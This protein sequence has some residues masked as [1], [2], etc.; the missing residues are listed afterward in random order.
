MTSGSDR[1]GV[2]RTDWYSFAS[3]ALELIYETSAPA[4]R[5]SWPGIEEGLDLVAPI[6]LVGDWEDAYLTLPGGWPAAA[7]NG[8]I[9]AAATPVATT[10]GRELPSG[11]L[12][13]RP[14]LRVALLER[15]G[16]DR[17]VMGP[18]VPMF[19][20]AKLPSNLAAGLFASHNEYMLRYCGEDTDRL[21][22]IG[23]LHGNEAEWAAREAQDLAA[24]KAFAGLAIYLPVRVG[25]DSRDF[26]PIWR[27]VQDSGLPVVHRLGL[28][29]SVW[30]GERL[31]SYLASSGVL[32]E[33][34]GLRFVLVGTSRQDVERIAA[35]SS[36]GADVVREALD[37]GR[38][39]IATTAAES[40]GELWYSD[41]PFAELP[42][43]KAT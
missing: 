9:R 37:S 1:E 21:Q 2:G 27:A 18:A 32:A 30:T 4:L 11:L 28:S 17:Q 42:G 8:S 19:N 36:A 29:S 24:E 22:A 31:I 41:F 39:R 34:D 33:F 13:D 40:E 3:P 20:A 5:G 10:R 23:L 15:C 7:T 38:I 12:Q 35:S 6:P 25:P 16:V 26:K 43:E 14:D